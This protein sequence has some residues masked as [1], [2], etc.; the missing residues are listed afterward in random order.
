MAGGQMKMA[1]ELAEVKASTRVID[2]NILVPNLMFS[3]G[4]ISDIW[5]GQFYPIC[6]YIVFPK[7]EFFSGI[8]TPTRN[9]RM[10]YH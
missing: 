6:P 3:M 1:H 10:L 7:F 4:H 8:A 5:V 9:K 2:T